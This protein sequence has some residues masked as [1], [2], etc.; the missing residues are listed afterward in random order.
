MFFILKNVMVKISKLKEFAERQSNHFNVIDVQSYYK[1]E[2]FG[3][4]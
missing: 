3:K 4:F 2:N 1:S